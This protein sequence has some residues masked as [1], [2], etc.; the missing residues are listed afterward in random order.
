MKST[1]QPP[2]SSISQRLLTVFVLTAILITLATPGLAL[3]APNPA[4]A[5]YIIV[6]KDT[7]DPST[8]APRLAKAFEMQPGFIYQHALKGMSAVVPA[9]R[10]EA[11][12]HDPRVAYV[13]EDLPRSISDQSMPTGIQRIFASTNTEITINGSDDW[14]VDVDVAV[15]DTGVDFQHPDLSVAGGVNCYGWWPC[16]ASCRTG[17]NDDHSH[18]THVAG[19]IAAYGQRGRRGGSRAWRPHLGRQG[20]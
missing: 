8:E 19:T 15:I 14:R 9:G 7:V 1:I 6:F 18:G 12:K 13:V 2:V 3:A 20:A 4:G 17:G 5:A 10:L 16:S 11:L